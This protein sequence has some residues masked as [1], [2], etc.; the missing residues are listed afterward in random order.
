MKILMV[1]KFLYPRGGAETYMLRI[2]EFLSRQG[3]QVE[4]FGMFDEK[5]TVG[6][7]AGQYTG[8]M[9]FHSSGLARFAYP[10]RI[11]YSLEAKKKIAK[12][13][14]AFRPDVVHLNNI[15]FQLTPSIIDAI[16]SRGIPVV[17]TVH[18]YQMVCP[19]HL[20][21]NYQEGSPCRRCIGGSKWNCAK[22]KCIHGSRVKSILGSLEDLLYKAHSAYDKVDCYI[23]PS[24]FLEQRLLEGSP[25][26]RGK[27]V[28]IH[29]YIELPEVPRKGEKGGYVAFASRL[30]KEK[31]VHLLAQAARMLP[32]YPF[33]IMGTGDEAHAFEGIEIVTMTGFLTG[34]RLT[35]TIAGAAFL[36]VPSICYENCPLS[37]LEAQAL[38]VPVV[39]MNMGGMAELVRHGQTGL[40][41]DKAEPQALAEAIRQLMESPEMLE[42]MRK[43]CLASRSEMITMDR[44][45]QKLMDIYQ[46]VKEASPCSRK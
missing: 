25:R 9:D 3:H 16:H 13:L 2:G 37:I 40:L 23:C 39:T 18:D 7:S 15:N 42:Q 8:N 6:N 27:T 33:V 31:G 17:Q 22:Y 44:Y 46:T 43:N 38:G 5:N 45:C 24:V 30:S 4:Y 34:S 28:A 19:N 41:V 29:N 11:L 21:Y 20:L 26:Y 12:V 1:N 10:F 36:V 14:D 35:E 32:E